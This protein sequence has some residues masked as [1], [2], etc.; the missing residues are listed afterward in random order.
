MVLKWLTNQEQETYDRIVY[1]EENLRLMRA[2]IDG[3]DV[4]VIVSFTDD[5]DVK[6]GE[7]GHRVSAE[8]LAILI[9]EELFNRLTPPDN[10]IEAMIA[11]E[12]DLGN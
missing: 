7:D 5:E 8:P 10:P 6:E 3:D 2:S 4:A 9:N 11:E 12:K 1:G